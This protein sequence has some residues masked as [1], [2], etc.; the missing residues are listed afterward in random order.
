MEFA[1]MELSSRYTSF[2]LSSTPSLLRLEPTLD[3]T[4]AARNVPSQVGMVPLLLNF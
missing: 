1:L 2:F 4:I 3:I